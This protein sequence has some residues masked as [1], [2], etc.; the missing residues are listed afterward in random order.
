VKNKQSQGNENVDS[1]QK[2]SRKEPQREQREVMT[3]KVAGAHTCVPTHPTENVDISREGWKS[4][5]FKA[6]KRRTE[7]RERDER[8]TRDERKD[9][10][11]TER[12]Y[13]QCV[14]IDNGITMER[15]EAFH[16]LLSRFR[17]RKGNINVKQTIHSSKS[18]TKE[19]KYPR[20]LFSADMKFLM[21]L[22]SSTFIETLKKAKK[23]K[24]APRP[25]CRD[26]LSC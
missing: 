4:E 22:S 11:R 16:H 14:P 3:W 2:N 26:F 24:E 23:T 19:S 13:L 7:K 21:I 18:H 1:Q 15:I 6:E 10:N 17:L 20:F 5:L 12:K 9:M 25:L 8:E